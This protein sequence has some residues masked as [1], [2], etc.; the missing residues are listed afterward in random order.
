[1]VNGAL[2]LSGQQNALTEGVLADLRLRAIEAPA[3]EIGWI[4]SQGVFGSRRLKLHK[5]TLAVQP[6]QFYGP[7]TRDRPGINFF[8]NC[9]FPDRPRRTNLIG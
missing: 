1:M 8:E 4:L 9:L 6:W 5:R 2:S 7:P 3:E